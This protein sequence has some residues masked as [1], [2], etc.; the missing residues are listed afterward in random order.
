MNIFNNHTTF[1]PIVSVVLPTYNR[2]NILKQVLVSLENQSVQGGLFEIVVTDDYSTDGTREFLSTYNRRNNNCFKLL[3]AEKN[4]G[5]ARA[6]NLALKVASGELII[7]IGDDIVVRHDFVEKHI[8]W[9]DLHKNPEEAVLGY[10]GWPES[11]YP[12]KFMYW[13]Y[14]GGRNFFFNF[15]SFCS[16]E[17]IDC[18]NFYTCNVSIKQKFLKN[19]LFDETFTYASHEDLELGERLGR[20]G[21]KLYYCADIQAQHHHFLKIEGIAKRVYL[22]GRSAHIFWNKIPDSSSFLKRKMRTILINCASFP[23]VY[24][25]LLTLLKIREKQDIDYPIRWKLILM[26][27]YWLGFSDAQ[28]DKKIRTFREKVG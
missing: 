7:I 28:K 20:K 24:C 23:G 6:R 17:Q 25:C 2:L 22:M 11:I 1:R 9:H 19:E 27:S 5:P 14:Y 12:S 16:G 15:S 13:L 10:V 21:M 8:L 26:M 18:Q 4:S 3:L